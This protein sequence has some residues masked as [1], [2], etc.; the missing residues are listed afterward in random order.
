MLAVVPEVGGG[1]GRR[2][3]A[4]ESGERGD[5][6]SLP[7]LRLVRVAPQWWCDYCWCR[8]RRESQACRL[9][10]PWRRR[11]MSRSSRTVVAEAEKDSED[12]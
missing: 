3:V 9:Y 8:H 11:D 10:S 2:G 6:V 12:Q 7:S 4:V 5:S 1:F